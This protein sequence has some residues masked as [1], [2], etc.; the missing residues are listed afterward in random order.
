MSSEFPKLITSSVVRGSEKGQSH[1]GVYIVDFASQTVE[2][3]IDWNKSD[4]D[5]A[6]RGWDRGLRGIEFSDDLIWIAASDELFAYNKSFRLVASYK[7]QYLKHCH[8]I[9]KRDNLLFLTSTGYDSILAFDLAAQQFIWGIYVSKN[10]VDWVG[11]PFDP[12]ASSG[13]PFANHYHL[14]NVHVDSTGVYLSGLQTNAILFLDSKMQVTEFCTLPS[15]THNAR[16]F[17]DGALFNDTAKNTVRYI[18]REGKQRAFDV[19]GFD[20][21]DLTGTGL[22]DSRIARQRFARGLC[23]INNRFIAGGSSPSTISIY[24]L[25]TGKRLGSVNL[26]MDVRNAI[27][28]LEVWPF[29]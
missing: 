11:Q 8:E 10:G 18:N 22:D 2:Q 12:N 21:R 15:G 26:T 6:G 1:G 28:G 20:N 7:N 23:V 13:P 24:D 17:L 9:C 16:P 3:H 27:H 29:Q 4:I 25:A 5:F 14:N 19:I